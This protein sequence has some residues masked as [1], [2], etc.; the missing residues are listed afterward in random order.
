M[1]TSGTVSQTTF[2]TRQVVDHAFRQCRLRP[3][4]IGAEQLQTAT[5]CLYLL[6]SE[7]PNYGI[8]LWTIEKRILPLYEALADV[9]LPDGTVD[10]LNQNWRQLT[11]ASGTN[12]SSA[13]GT[14]ANAFDDDF[15]TACT[16]TATNGNIQTLFAAETQV[17][18]VGY[19]SNATA[20]DFDAVIE[21]SDDGVT[22]TTVLTITDA[23]M[24]DEEWQWWDLDGAV[25]SLY[26]RFRATGGATI[27]VRELYWGNTP[28]EIPLA[29]ISQDNYT[30]LPNKTFQGQ[31]VQ[32]WLDRQRAAPVMHLWPVPGYTQRYG[33][34]TVW[35]TRQV[36]DVGLLS[37][38]LDIPQRWYRAVVAMLAAAI[39]VEI[40]EVDGEWAVSLYKLAYA[41]DDGALARAMQ[42]EED[43][44]PFMITPQISAY[45]A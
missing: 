30:A 20:P 9:T 38:T 42:E 6:L 11:R 27:D 26:W 21:R 37:Q 23:D 17:T 33:Q 24:V 15:D 14:V 29:P 12:T 34:L 4:Q 5:E 2:T 44:M 45:T 10:V 22:W 36:E 16:Q 31:P 8:Q 18:T 40:P 35:R 43:G 7:L 41:P 28:Q 25:A 1:T 39:A 19:L 3:Q 13:G 32:F